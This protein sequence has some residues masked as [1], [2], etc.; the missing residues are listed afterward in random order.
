MAAS[1]ALLAGALACWVSHAQTA[2]PGK[3]I[4][5]EEE[6]LLFSLSLG[7][8]PLAEVFPVYATASG[9]CLVPLGEL[10]RALGIGIRV[11]PG[12]RLAQGFILTE[13]RRFRLDFDAGQVALDGRILA[14]D[15]S[16]MAW[17]DGD[18]YVAIPL[19]QQWL[20]VTL[21][22]EPLAA[23]LRV[24]AREELPIQAEWRRAAPRGVYP[25][26]QFGSSP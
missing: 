12:A 11:D 15:R 23:T 24:E 13:A 4:R 9:G 22:A 26:R 2:P 5:A 1:H 14:L 21:T 6:L 8:T 17:H 7:R 3:V 19:L 25:P 18:L 10:C 20:P 16:Q